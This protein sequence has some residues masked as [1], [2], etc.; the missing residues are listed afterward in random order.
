MAEPSVDILRGTLDLLILKALSWGPSHGFGVAR[1]IEQATDDVLR[2]EEG[3]LYPALHRL[4]ARDWIEA[5]WGV[6]ENNRKAKFYRLTTQ[7]RQ[8]L[9]AETVTWTRFANAVFAALDAPAQPA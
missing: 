8:R 6:S 9:R 3:S 2:V 5:E 4:E 7:G 1:W